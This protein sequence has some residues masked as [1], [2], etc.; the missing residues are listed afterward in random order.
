[1]DSAAMVER[2]RSPASAS[3]AVAMASGVS[4]SPKPWSPRPRIS[5]PRPSGRAA[6]TPPSV[7]TPSTTRTT[8]R[9]CGPSPS[10]PTT[11]V[12]TAPTSNVTVRDHWASG[13]YV[14]MVL[15]IAGTSGAPRL[16]MT[17]T[18]VP[19]KSSTVTRAR[20][21]LWRG[22]GTTAMLPASQV[23]AISNQRVGRRSSSL[24]RLRAETG[25]TPYPQGQGVAPV[26]VR[27]RPYGSGRPVVHMHVVHVVRRR[28]PAVLHLLPRAGRRGED[29]LL[30]DDV[31][32]AELVP[33]VEVVPD[34]RV[35][36]GGVA[37]DHVVQR[38][39]GRVAVG[40][41]RAGSGAADGDPG[42]ARD[43]GDDRVGGGLRPRLHVTGA[44]A[45][46]S[47][48][49]G[50][51][52]G[53]GR[54]RGRGRRG[55]GGPLR[56]GGGQHLTPEDPVGGAADDVDVALVQIARRLAV[57]GGDRR[58]RVAGPDRVVAHGGG[59]AA[60]GVGVD[61]LDRRGG[62]ARL[63]GSGGR[64]GS[65]RLHG[66]HGGAA[67]QAL[68]A[69]RPGTDALAGEHLLGDLDLLARGRQVRA[70]R[71]G[72]APVR[73]P[74]RLAELQPA[75]VAV[76]GVGAPVPAG[77]ALGHAGP[78]MGGGG[79]GRSGGGQNAESHDGGACGDGNA[80][81]DLLGADIARRTMFGH[82]DVSDHRRRGELSGS[83]DRC[84]AAKRGFT[85]RRAWARRERGSPTPALRTPGMTAGGQGL[86]DRRRALC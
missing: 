64:R 1:M 59:V 36:E 46:A 41:H 26:C 50:R 45:D 29:L 16:L 83:D 33:V 8:L 72:A 3:R 38:Q 48:G 69:G 68:P 81:D 10:L 74:G 21:E 86:A 54:R 47:D 22:E 53:R 70:G 9:R 24:P 5:H 32:H 85:P 2:D 78:V 66:G 51:L 82:G 6:S 57:G 63:L 14:P 20:G 79:L 30:P 13:S 76:A 75:V 71:E 42:G 65:G 52:G 15:A 40:V 39:P 77:L 4:P 12:A 17:A 37:R 58:D 25:A 61:G 35:P 28:A 34:H 80:R 49:L 7:T 31:L 43:V 56:P 60:V 11:G 62:S 23:V 18:T 73:G 84:P 55:G 27:A 19:T 44:V 67:R